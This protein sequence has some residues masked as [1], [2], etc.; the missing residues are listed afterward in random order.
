MIVTK[1]KNNDMIIFNLHQ[2]KAAGKTVESAL[3]RRL[4]H[5]V[6]RVSKIFPDIAVKNIARYEL[7]WRD[8]PSAIKQDVKV[9]TG[10]FYYGL[11]RA[12]DRQFTYTTAIRPPIP[13]LKSFYNYVMNG[14]NDYFLRKFILE[15]DLDFDRFCRLG[16][17]AKPTSYPHEFSII[18]DN[19][20]SRLIHGSPVKLGHHMTEG[21]FDAVMA[22]I[23]NSFSIIAPA[24]RAAEFCVH[25]LWLAETKPPYFLPR[26]NKGEK[27][28]VGEIAKST[29]D[30]LQE[31]HRYDQRLYDFACSTFEDSCSTWR[32]RVTSQL[33]ELSGDLY[34]K[35]RKY[36]GKKR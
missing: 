30:Y 16:D 27:D 13:R 29:V 33:I 24:D 12:T 23:E 4:G 2:Q 25:L 21:E 35:Y 20:Q 31:R 1:H 7:A 36:W 18:A 19:G 17:E 5:K 32:S 28:W 14:G 15:N 8:Q 34:D 10:H 22:N 9:V 26:V 6:A 11:H 3:E